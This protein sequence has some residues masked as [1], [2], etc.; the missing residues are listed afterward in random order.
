MLR[1]TWSRCFLSP[2]ACVTTCDAKK[3]ARSPGPLSDRTP[4][5]A[6]YQMA[7][8]GFWRPSGNFVIFYRHDGLGIPS[9]GIVLLG[10]VDS[11]AEVFDIPGAVEVTVT[12]AN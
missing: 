8:L 1:V 2:S 4:G 10:K 11:N 7:D 5:S 6:V 12:L 3:P 9:P